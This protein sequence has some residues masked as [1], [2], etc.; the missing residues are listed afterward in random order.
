MEDLQA[1]NQTVTAPDKTAKAN[2]A[3]S[4]FLVTANVLIFYL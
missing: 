3:R 4:G 1:Q 2:E